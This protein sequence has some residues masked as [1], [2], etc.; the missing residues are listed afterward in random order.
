MEEETKPEDDDTKMKHHLL[1]SNNDFCEYDVAFRIPL[2]SI[3]VTGSDSGL[4]DTFRIN[5]KPFLA[6]SVCTPVLHG[7]Y[8]NKS[9]VNASNSC[10]IPEYVER[11]QSFDALSELDIPNKIQIK[12]SCS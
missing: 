1:G 3:L 10:S 9:T 5:A 12:Y 7:D 11:M 2:L 4:D 8:P 6:E